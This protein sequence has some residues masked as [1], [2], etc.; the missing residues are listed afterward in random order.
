MS[1]WQP[2]LN[3]NDDNEE[4]KENDIPN[5]E[6]VVKPRTINRCEEKKLEKIQKKTIL[7]YIYNRWWLRNSSDFNWM[8]HSMI[9]LLFVYSGIIG[10][11]I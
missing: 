9:L 8:T 6:P 1:S 4:A 5:I 7:F 3:E 2:P 11:I 10:Q